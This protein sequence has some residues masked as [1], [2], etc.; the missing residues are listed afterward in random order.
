MSFANPNHPVIKETEDQ[1][2]KIAA[3]IMVKYNLTKVTITIEDI[4]K[5]SKLPTKNLLM[6]V[7]K[8]CIDLT[9][10]SDTEARILATQN[11]G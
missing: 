11:G 4:D 9:F 8:N 7:H 3:L 2:Y 6:H 5:L 1:W 10:V